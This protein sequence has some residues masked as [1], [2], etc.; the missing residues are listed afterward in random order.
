MWRKL[1]LSACC[2]LVANAAFSQLKTATV[3]DAI[4]YNGKILTVDPGFSV[5]QAFAVRGDEILAVGTNAAVR[6]LAGPN[7]P[8]TPRPRSCKHCR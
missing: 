1:I 7:E 4:F 6:A 2:V 8:S 3:P 5:Q